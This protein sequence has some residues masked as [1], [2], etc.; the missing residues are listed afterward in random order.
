MVIDILA[1]DVNQPEFGV[2]MI[3][4]GVE[5]GGGEQ[6]ALIGTVARIADLRAHRDGRYTLVAVGAARFRVNAW[7]PDD[8]YPVAD[9]DLWPDVDAGLIDGTVA[10]SKVAELHARVRRI[11]ADVLALGDLAPLP[12][13]EIS[14]DPQLAIYHLGSLSPLGPAD[15]FRMLAAPGLTARLDVLAAALDDAEA[16]IRFRSS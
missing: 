7:L 12:D 15:R 11:N 16:M 13:T 2:V 3:E 6:R 1:D 14:D 9:V 10:R 4:R 5:V 8:P